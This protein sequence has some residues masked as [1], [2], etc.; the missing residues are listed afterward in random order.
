MHM[1]IYAL[2]GT[3]TPVIYILK[4]VN[5]EGKVVPVLF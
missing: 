3:R 1:N 2:R 4:K 5:D